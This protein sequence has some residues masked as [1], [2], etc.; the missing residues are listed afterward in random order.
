MII[1][2]QV[3]DVLPCVDAFL[4]L[5]PYNHDQRL[6]ASPTHLLF[7]KQTPLAPENEAIKLA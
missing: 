5:P 1:Q 2:H 6:L 3:V 7:L 4:L